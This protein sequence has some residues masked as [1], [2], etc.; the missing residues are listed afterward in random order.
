[1]S[2]GFKKY[3]LLLFI[4][5]T[6]QMVVIAQDGFGPPV[7]KQDFGVGTPDPSTVG[8]PLPAGKTY[9]SFSNSVCPPPGSYTI[10]RRVPVANCF[11]NEWIGLSHDNNVFV[12]YGMMMMV[13]VNSD[14]NNRVVYVDTVNQTLCPG[15]KYRFSAAYINLDLIDGLGQC[16]NGPDY[17]FF[18]MRLEDGSGNLIVKDTTPPFSSYAAP[19]L[20]G[21]K[22]SEYF[23]DFTA[24]VPINKMI[25]KITL[26]RHI[27]E[28][29]E[30]FAIDDIQIRPLGPDATITFD[31]DLPT[32]IVKAV[33]FQ[34]NSIVSMTGTIEDY[35]TNTALQWQQST[36]NGATWTDIPGATSFTYSSIFSV[37]DTFLF[38]LTGGE[39]ATIS[40][41]NCR[42]A[43]NVLKLEVDGLPKNYTITNNSPVCSGQDLK[44]E[45]SGAAAYNWTGPNGFHDNIATPHIF[46]SALADSGWYYVDVFSRGG[47]VKK[48][49]THATIIGTDVHAGPDT[50]ICK[51]NSVR[52]HASAGATYEWT[53]SAGLSSTNVSSPTAKPDVTTEYTVKVTDSHGC[54]DTAKVQVMILNKVAAKAIISGTEH[55]CRLYDSASFKDVSAGIIAHRE[56]D[57]GNGVSDTTINPAIQYY[58]I[59]SSQEFYI[60]RLAVRDT[61][62]CVDTAYQ[63][64]RV[65]DNCYIAV[66]TAFTPN[67]DGL[68]DELGPLNAYKATDLAF[69][70][71]NRHGQVVFETKDWTR[72]WNGT[73][74]GIKMDSGVYVWTL[75]YLDASHRRIQLKGTSVLIR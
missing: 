27:C 69:R 68:N 8:T 50:G 75:N 9:F 40:N 36:N 45:G 47:C 34:N 26:L 65:E 16:T 13:N 29:A 7:F 60:V 52:L 21:Y 15:G 30:D 33:C 71:Y 25:L 64:M 63:V 62:D 44:F 70:I 19:P 59:P 20:M 23:I 28:C 17:P 3:C 74:G 39:A 46:F 24:T 53:P 54:N 56:W 48:D 58:T 51:G 31:S 11:N 2:N 5:I 14:I 22:F 61:A 35:Y 6:G 38:R 73:K 55:L 18:E 10:V 12:D 43:S 72:K 42:V 49:S 1:M 41:P 67:G 66:P 4:F 37:P 57:F 32:T